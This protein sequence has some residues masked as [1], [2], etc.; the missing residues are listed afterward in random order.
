MGSNGDFSVPQKE[1]SL[2]EQWQLRLSESAL[3]DPTTLLAEY[4]EAGLPEILEVVL[5]DQHA[6]WQAEP[7]PRV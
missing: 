5:M 7:G 2:T 4:P 3:A 6:K 1:L